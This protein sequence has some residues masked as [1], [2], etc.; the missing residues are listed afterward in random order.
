MSCGLIM[1][2]M[3]CVSGLWPFITNKYY[4]NRQL[5]CWLTDSV[6]KYLNTAAFKYYLNIRSRIIK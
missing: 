6:V 3:C 5:V 1:L 4:Y 2:F